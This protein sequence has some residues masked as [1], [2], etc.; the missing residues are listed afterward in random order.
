MVTRPALSVLDL[1]PVADGSTMREAIDISMQAAQQADDQ[2]YE[3]Y[4]FAEHHNT[5]NLASNATALLISRAA[6]RTERIRVGSG[7]IMLPNHAPL[8][9]AEQF[10]TLI[11]FHGDRIDLGLGRAPGTDPMTAQLLA[12]TSAQPEAFMSGIADIQ[13]WSGPRTTANSR[14]GAYVAEGTHIP[15]WVLGSSMNGAAMAAQLGLPFSVASHFA[16]FQFQQALDLYRR[17][18]D[19]TAPTAQIEQPRTMV[20]VNVVVCDTDDEAQ[21]Q[22]SVLQQMFA[23]IIKGARGP[24]PRPARIGDVLEPHILDSVNQ[25]LSISAVGSPSTVV[26]KLEELAAA[27]GADEFITVSYFHDP[28]KR[29]DSQR[30]LAEAWHG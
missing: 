30:M 26:A 12:R 25:S 2:G 29:F 3:R 23:G 19:P 7:G 18:F 8:A 17:E 24:L 14:I 13:A 21:F 28:Q 15:M 20:G 22:F 4:W 1:V 9:V 10:G 27:T 5:Q 6:E 11:Q 16:P